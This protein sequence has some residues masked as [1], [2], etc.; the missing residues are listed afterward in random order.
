MIDEVREGNMIMYLINS[1]YVHWGVEM[2]KADHRTIRNTRNHMY[3]I[4]PM[5]VTTPRHPNFAF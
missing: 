1:F 2:T 5:L 3:K 4:I